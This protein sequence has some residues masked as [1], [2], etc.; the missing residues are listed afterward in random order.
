MWIG[1]GLFG[2]RK[3][4]FVAMAALFHVLAMGAR[5]FLGS[6]V[7]NGGISEPHFTR[8]FYLVFPLFHETRHVNERYAMGTALCIGI[9]AFW[10]K[11]PL[12]EK[13]LG[14]HS[15]PWA[16][17]CGKHCPVSV[18]L[19]CAPFECGPSSPQQRALPA[20]LAPF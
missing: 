14:T 19:A 6:K 13:P 20:P 10:G 3:G 9:A 7:S 15:S 2:G 11:A 1:L 4:R 18:P 17:H 16:V 5:V 8:C 12:T